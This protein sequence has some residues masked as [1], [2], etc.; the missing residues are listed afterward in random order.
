[1][2]IQDAPERQE[3]VLVGVGRGYNLADVRTRPVRDGTLVRRLGALRC[4]AGAKSGDRGGGHIYMPMC[5]A[6]HRHHVFGTASCGASAV[7]RG[8][9]E[10]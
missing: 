2:C 1:M 6:Q 4:R 7:R 10:H 5:G 8:A 9:V 3:F